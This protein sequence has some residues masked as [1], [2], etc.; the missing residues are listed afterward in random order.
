MSFLLRDTNL[1]A[2]IPVEKK[3]NTR[4]FLLLLLKFVKSCTV[5]SPTGSRY[6]T[7]HSG[8]FS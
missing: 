1:E 5:K 6:L 2:A 4:C 7:E 3:K 8:A